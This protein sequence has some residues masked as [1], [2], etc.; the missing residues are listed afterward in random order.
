MLFLLQAQKTLVDNI[1]SD[2]QNV[3]HEPE[4]IWAKNI[5]TSTPIYEKV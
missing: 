5:Q 1:I 4:N 2:N 3:F